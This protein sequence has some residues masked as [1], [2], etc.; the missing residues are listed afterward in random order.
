MRLVGSL[1]VL[2]VSAV[3][4]AAPPPSALARARAALDGGK[5][6]D[7]QKIVATVA[8][9]ERSEADALV[10]EAL[11]RTGRYAD[12]RKLLEATLQRDPAARAARLELGLVARAV[13]DEAAAKR[14][15]NAFFD[16]YE[17]GRIDKNRPRELLWVALAARYL[18][19]WQDANDVF[20]EAVDLD[21]GDKVE[22]ARAQIEWAALFLEKYDAGHAERE[23][24]GALKALPDD[25]DAHAL[26]A[27]VKLEQGYD[28]VAAEKEIAR[29]LKANP[30]HAEALALRAE[31]FVDTEAYEK[32]LAVCEEIEKT[33]PEDL[34]A[35]TVAAAA[36][37][38]MEDRKGYE[39]E[40]A[41]VLATNPR[42]SSFYVG[43]SD[44]LVKQ[45]RYDDVSAILDEAVKLNPKDW[46]ALAGL[47]A[48][49]LR[50]GDE[51]RGLEMLRRA[52]KGDRFNVRTYNLLNL[53]EDIIPKQYVLSEPAKGAAPIALRVPKG[54]RAL[55]EKYV[56]PLLERAYADMVKR[57]GFTPKGP[58]V[59]ELYGDNEHYAVRTVGLPG[60]EAL[61]V[62]FERVVTSM[63][64]SGGRFNWG[65]TLWHELGH[66]FSIQL[67]K[68]RVPRWFT[69][70]L[71]EYETARE[72]PEWSRHTYAEL[73]RALSDGKLYSVGQLNEA[74]LRAR[75][76][77]HMVIAYHQSAETVTFLARRFGFPK[78]VEA[79]KLFGDGK[80]TPEVIRRV[81]GMDVAAFDRAFRED[82]AARLQP[83]KGTLYVRHSD[84]SDV[85]GLRERMKAG[86]RKAA[87]LVAWALMKGRHADEAKKIV[88]EARA[89]KDLTI[90]ERRLVDL[91]AAQLAVNV[92]QWDLAKALLDDLVNKIGGDGADARML[93]GQVAVAEG[94][95]ADAEKEYA[96]AKRMDPHRP[97]PAVELFRLYDKAGRTDAALRELEEAARLDCMDAS[98]QLKLLSETAKA[99]RWAKVLELAPLALY[100]AP[101]E[102]KVQRAIAEALV[103]EGKMKEALEAIDA[104]LAAD[105]D[106][107]TKAALR[108]LAER[109]G[110]I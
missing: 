10:G 95:T 9:S 35:R 38:L 51:K 47:G 68:S 87:A 3:A 99:K 76:V 66:V 101:G 107:E 42:A 48:N 56:R 61:G 11:R 81:T 50:L 6:G 62:T 17:Q 93:R 71:S 78:V 104:A 79:L 64:P 108:A 89:R 88:D 41:R 1:A 84:Y 16:D 2:V 19:S 8:A 65:M 97:E 106:D 33:N 44:F 110:R 27:R 25:A 45:H 85:E 30:R 15:W 7:V 43:V 40:R 102:P 60:L 14:I 49:A 75:D 73:N 67:S 63:S 96:A 94:R 77:A 53:F 90:D 54:D 12:A 55:V 105:P 58:V 100:V 109:A 22:R 4:H 28:V 74:F 20:R 18:E 5:Y 57:Y 23:L 32:A 37:W 34:R 98:L 80:R 92:K 72:R 24:E 36:R 52:W 86:D 103:A 91:A 31:L 82:L 46:A 39:A 70:G 13:G 21:G 59:V 83:Y 69:E 26:M 29:A